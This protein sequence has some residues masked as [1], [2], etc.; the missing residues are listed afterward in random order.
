MW[1]VGD[2]FRLIR[3]AENLLPQELANIERI[4]VLIPILQYCEIIDEH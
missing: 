4:E 1:L 3:S 2:G